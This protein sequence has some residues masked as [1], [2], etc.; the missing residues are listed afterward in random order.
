MHRAGRLSVPAALAML[1]IAVSDGALAEGGPRFVPGQWVTYVAPALRP[2]APEIKLVVF[3]PERKPEADERIPARDSAAEKAPTE[4]RCAAPWQLL[5]PRKLPSPDG[6]SAASPQR[7]R[8]QGAWGLSPSG[9]DRLV[10]YPKRA[11]ASARPPAMPDPA[12]SAGDEFFF[13]AKAPGESPWT[14]AATG[15]IVPGSWVTLVDGKRTTT[16]FVA[17]TTVAD[18]DVLPDLPKQERRILCGAKLHP[19]GPNGMTLGRT[20][21]APPYGRWVPDP[22]GSKRWAWLPSAAPP[23]AFRPTASPS[24]PPPVLRRKCSWFEDADPS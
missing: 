12:P 19:S 1:T 17:N 4:L 6:T 24:D 15:K 18:G 9:E 8:D 20:K 23:F 21:P 10:W 11:G 13:C 22:F 14:K 2:R 16:L 3:V 5:R 7:G